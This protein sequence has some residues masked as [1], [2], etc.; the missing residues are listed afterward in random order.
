MVK[1]PLT[2][3]HELSRA[4]AQASS[5]DAIYKIILDEV[6]TSLDVER[7]SIMRYDSKN[8]VL[9]IV[10]AKGIEPEVWKNVEISV[11]EGV[12]G[13]VWQEGKPLLIQK[14]K[15]NP[16]YKTHSFMVAPVTAFPMKVGSVPIGLINLTDKKSGKPFTQSDLQLLM[17]LS[18]QVASYM[19]ISDLVEQ[20][21]IAEQTKLE[22]EWAR[23]IQQRLLP[24][25]DQ[26]FEGVEMEGC[27]IPATRVG[28]D[29]YDFFPTDGEGIGISIADVSGHGVGGALLAFATRASLR[30]QA[31]GQK[32]PGVILQAVNQMLFSDLLR[33]E[34]FVSLFYAHYLPLSRTL[35][36]TNGGHPPP[37]FW[38]AKTQEI[39]WLLTQDALLGIEPHQPYKEK[40]LELASNDLVVLYTDGLT[41][42][43]NDNGKRLGTDPLVQIVAECAKNKARDILHHLLNHWKKFIGKQAVKDDVTVVV[44]KVL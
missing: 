23:E 9:R 25:Q 42:A 34:Q 39:Y 4:I 22:M 33:A 1:Q 28:A 44:V 32:S 21:K 38:Q 11:G 30:A 18:D 3:L 20:L 40:K 7:A 6:V 2:L 5:L 16:R 43:I 13:R 31:N 35:V 17:T 26:S 27:L 29:Y 14:M 36:Y 41:E 19:H 8:Q 37:L 10:A 24:E 15:P 12:S